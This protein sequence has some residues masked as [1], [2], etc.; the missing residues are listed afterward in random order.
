MIRAE[1]TASDT[2]LAAPSSQFVGLIAWIIGIFDRIPHALVAFAARIFPAAVFWQSGQTKMEGWHVSDNAIYLF[3]EE[4]KLPLIDPVGRRP[5]CGLRRACLSD[6]ARHRPRQP[7]RGA[8]P[9][10][11]DARH[12]D[13]R[14]SRRLAHAWRV[15]DVFPPRHRARP[16]RPL[17]RSRHRAALRAKEALNRHRAIVRYL[18]RLELAKAAP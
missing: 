15:G 4:Y 11:H 14:L 3:R 12:R 9:S 16:G 17:A 13:L 10:L 8:R 6:P 5:S 7:V 2:A 1:L 18:L